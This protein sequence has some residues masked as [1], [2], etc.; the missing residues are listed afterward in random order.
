MNLWLVVYLTGWL[1]AA[2]ALG[3]QH[4]KKYSSRNDT[5][6]LPV[7]ALF[8]PIIVLY[9][10]VWLGQSLVDWRESGSASKGANELEYYK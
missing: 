2:F 3:W 4:A 9:F 1:I 7:L 6:L 5:E 10:P 8:W